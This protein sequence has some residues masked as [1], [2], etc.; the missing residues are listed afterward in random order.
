MQFFADLD[1]EGKLFFTIDRG[2]RIV[3]KEQAAHYVHYADDLEEVKEFFRLYYQEDTIDYDE[4]EE[5]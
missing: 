4:F 1:S 3:D 2:I 5:A